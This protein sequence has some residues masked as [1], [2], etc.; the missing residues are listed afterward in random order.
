MGKLKWQQYVL[1]FVVF[2]SYKNKTMLFTS[3]NCENKGYFHF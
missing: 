1:V 2:P 3:S